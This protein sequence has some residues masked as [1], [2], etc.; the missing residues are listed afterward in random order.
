VLD[1]GFLNAT[2]EAP[3]HAF[4]QEAYSARCGLHERTKNIQ[5]WQ[6]CKFNFRD[7]P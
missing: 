5:E 6:C 4:T 7:L 1:Y 3:N 2:F